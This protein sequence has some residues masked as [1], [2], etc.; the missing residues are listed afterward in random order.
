ML[1][2]QRTLHSE[3]FCACCEAWIFP[4]L[5]I[6]AHLACQSVACMQYADEMIGD[7]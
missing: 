2:A 1:K 7:R 6:Q 3:V 4:K 5:V